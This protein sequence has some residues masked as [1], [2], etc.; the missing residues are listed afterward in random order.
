MGFAA[1]CGVDVCIAQN[2]QFGCVVIVDYLEAI[3]PYASVPTT[4]IRMGLVGNLLWRRYPELRPKIFREVCV[5]FEQSIEY[6]FD[7]VGAPSTTELCELLYYDCIA[8]AIRARDFD[9][10]KYALSVIIE[11]LEFRDGTP[12]GGLYGD[13]IRDGIISLLEPEDT[14][15]LRLA[16]AEATEVIRQHFGMNKRFGYILPDSES[17]G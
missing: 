15:V 7:Y 2:G 5:E 3:D 17:E 6:D 16:D 8:P 12:P 13:A 14:V 9:Q 10:L 4:Y 11:M 1:L